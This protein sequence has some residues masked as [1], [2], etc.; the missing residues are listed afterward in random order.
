[1]ARRSLGNRQARRVDLVARHAARRAGLK[2]IVIHPDTDPAARADAV[3]RLARLPRDSS[4]VRLRSRDVVD[5]RPRGIL[6]RFGLSRV[7]FREMALRG[8]LPGIRKA[9][10]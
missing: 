5:G 9:S 6:S 7:R 3:R 1:M 10:R 8:E 2:Q 4:P